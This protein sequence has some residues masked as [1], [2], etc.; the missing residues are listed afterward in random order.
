MEKNL[1]ISLAITLTLKKLLHRSCSR[2]LATKVRAHP[3]WVGDDSNAAK[4]QSIRIPTG[5]DRQI[6]VTHAICMPYAGVVKNLE[7]FVSQLK[8]F[9]MKAAS[10]LGTACTMTRVPPII[11]ATTV[12]KNCK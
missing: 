9:P 1:H 12:V 7:I 11:H 6:I 2:D 3:L 5:G 8:R 4:I 10:K